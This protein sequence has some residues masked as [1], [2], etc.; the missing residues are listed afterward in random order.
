MLG[1]VHEALNQAFELSAPVS[2]QPSLVFAIV[3]RSSFRLCLPFGQLCASI[4]S[5]FLL[6]FPCVH[7]FELLSSKSAPTCVQCFSRCQNG[8]N[9]DATGVAF[10]CLHSALLTLFRVGG[11]VVVAFVPS[12]G[13]P[14]LG[15]SGD[16]DILNFGHADADCCSACILSRTKQNRSQNGRRQMES[17]LPHFRIWKS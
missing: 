11:V 8:K 14:V 3:R 9:L 2:V 16:Q 12:F 10:A 17:C 6:P 1:P 15:T 5:M 4:A 13:P 7:S